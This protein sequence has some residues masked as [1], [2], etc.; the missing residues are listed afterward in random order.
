MRIGLETFASNADGSPGRFNLL[1]LEGVSVV[2]DYGHNVPSLEQICLV[3]RG[4]PHGRRIAV[5]SAAGDRRDEDMLEQGRLLGSEFDRVVVYEDAYIRGRQPGDI[6]RLIGQ[7]V[8]AAAPPR[9][10]AAESGG[11]WSQSVQ[12][13]LESARPGDLVLVQADVA[14]EAMPWL[15]E[16]YGSRLR[17]T[18]LDEMAAK[19]VARRLA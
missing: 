9:A 19:V 14:E 6:T 12:L 13:V 10:T 3:I 5:Y 15:T 11:N 8:A 1:D 16:K 18:T 2:V 4:L 17:E 7:G